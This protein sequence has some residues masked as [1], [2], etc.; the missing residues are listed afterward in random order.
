MDKSEKEDA[1]KILICGGSGISSSLTQ[2]MIEKFHERNQFRSIPPVNNLPKHGW[3]R[4]FEK[5]S[6]KFK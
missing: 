6:K 5:K 4:Q 1:L 2:A 3:Y